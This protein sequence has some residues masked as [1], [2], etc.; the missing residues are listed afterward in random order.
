VAGGREGGV[1]NIGFLKSQIDGTLI[2]G[3]TGVTMAESERESAARAKRKR[4]SKRATALREAQIVRALAQ[5]D[6]INEIAARE[7]RSLKR[8][9]KRVA[10]AVA[11]A[12]EPTEDVVA[13]QIARLSEAMQAAYG[14]MRDGD[15]A[16]VDGELKMTGELARYFGLALTL[17][18]RGDCD[19]ARD[20]RRRGAPAKPPAASRRTGARRSSRQ[21]DCE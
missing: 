1:D 14:S 16:A 6:S 12:R 20:G 13:V 11:R 18:R 5:G 15:L 7:G 4:A 21:A 3:G 2:F 17:A 10:A 8:A 19:P 9:R